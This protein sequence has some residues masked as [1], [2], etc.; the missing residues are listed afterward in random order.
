V[1][2]ARNAYARMKGGEAPHIQHTNYTA[3]PVKIVD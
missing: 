3:I 1:S 2:M